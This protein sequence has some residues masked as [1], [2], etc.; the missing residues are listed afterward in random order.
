LYRPTG[1]TLSKRKIEAN[2][3]FISPLR[4]R[5][6]NSGFKRFEEIDPLMTR[7]S[8]NF[9]SNDCAVSENSIGEGTV[10]RDIDNDAKMELISDSDKNPITPLTVF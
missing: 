1:R 3:L 4:I 2:P 7:Q 6:R 10:S 9:C 5:G 8:W